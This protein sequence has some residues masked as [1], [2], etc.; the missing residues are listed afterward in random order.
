MARASSA[1]SRTP[2]RIGLATYTSRNTGSTTAFRNLPDRS[3]LRQWGGHGS[4][5]GRFAR[6]QDMVIDEQDRL[7]VTDACNHRVQ[8]FDLE[9]NLL[10]AW[11]TPGSA[12]GELYFPYDLV[13]DG[14]GNVY[15]CEYG[16]HRVQKF[17]REGESLGCWG[18]EGREP[19]ELHNPWAV[20]RDSKGRLHVL[21]TNNHR[22]QR[23]DHVVPIGQ[24][25]HDR[26]QPASQRTDLTNVRLRNSLRR[27]GFLVL[28]LLIPLVW[29]W[30]Y[31]SLSALG[32]FR[33]LWVCLRSDRAL[34]RDG[35]GRVANGAA[36][37]SAGRRLPGRSIAEY[38]ARRAKP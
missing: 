5:P 3:F 18:H 7:W 2:S 38:P 26:F 30:G 25:S 31:R 34:G 27:A 33:R 10:F 28:V 14:D 36:Q 35:R 29:W 4:E 1:G 20:V 16:N 32:W 23:S 37:R 8:V 6:P 22:V 15:I 9:G 11:G 12:P 17:T 21:D 19:G 13:F 24:E